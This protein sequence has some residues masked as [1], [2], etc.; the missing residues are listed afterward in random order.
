MGRFLL[1]LIVAAAALGGGYYAFVMKAPPPLPSAPEAPAT[2]TRTLAADCFVENARYA[3]RGSPDV[4][5]TFEVPSMRPRTQAVPA[6]QFQFTEMLPTVYA[7]SAQG[8]TFRFIAAQSTGYT[9]PY[10]FPID[11]GGLVKRLR[12]ADLIAVGFF[13]G[14]YDHM[15]ALPRRG[16]TSPEYI[17]APGVARYMANATRDAV[18]MPSTNMFDFKGCDAGVKLQPPGEGQKAPDGYTPPRPL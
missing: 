14:T 9:T 17:F 7:F 6:D 15:S 1:I 11:E 5:L 4:I 12:D 13:N 3:L 18:V 16:F 8:Q 2:P 10:L